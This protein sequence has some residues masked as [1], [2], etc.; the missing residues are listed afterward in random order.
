[1]NANGKLPPLMVIRERSVTVYA[2]PGLAYRE[3]VST[4]G[5][6]V[7]HGGEVLGGGA[8]LSDWCDTTVSE[9]EDGAQATADELWCDVEC[10]VA[11]WTCADVEEVIRGLRCIGGEDDS[12]PGVPTISE[13]AGTATKRGG[14]P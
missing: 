5:D 12:V 14:A 9:D 6:L 11:N 10:E 3:Y 4:S 13:L 1:M 7:R 8:V 2:R